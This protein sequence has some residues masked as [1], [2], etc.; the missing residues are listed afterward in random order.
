MKLF[1]LLLAAI[2]F[3]GL[4]ISQAFAGDIQNSSDLLSEI[5]KSKDKQVVLVNFYASWCGPCRAEIPH[6]ISIRKKYSENDLKI[7]AI[8]LDDSKNTMEKFN[9]EMGINYSTYH[10]SGSIQQ[11]FMVQGIPFNLVYGKNGDAVYADS[12]I[13]SEQRLTEIIEYGL[14]K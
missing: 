6:L 4:S 14:Q 11:F 10:D 13:I 2:C 9:K 1:K 12:G 7:I 3:T 8:N 5:S